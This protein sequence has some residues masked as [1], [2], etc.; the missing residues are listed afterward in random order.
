MPFTNL[1]RKSPTSERKFSDVEQFIG[2]AE[3]YAAGLNSCNN[4]VGNGLNVVDLK[5][6][7]ANPALS[8]IQKVKPKMQ[9]ATFTLSREAKQQLDALSQQTGIARSRLIRI[10]LDVCQNELHTVDYC[11]S[12]VI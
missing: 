4:S 6:V 9:R 7:K 1:K 3:A 10:W 12:D 2:E 8:D 11:E 5:S